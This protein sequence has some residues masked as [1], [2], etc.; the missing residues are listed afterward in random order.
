M[1]RSRFPDQQLIKPMLGVIIQQ[2]ETLTLGNRRSLP[3]SKLM[4]HERDRGNGDEP[5]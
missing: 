4:V 5:R 2:F 3:D 1:R